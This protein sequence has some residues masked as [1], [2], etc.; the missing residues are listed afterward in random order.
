MRF[1]GI[2]L[3]VSASLGLL[4][5]GQKGPLQLPQQALPWQTPEVLVLLVN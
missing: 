2:L 5:C 1:I 4:S 3:I